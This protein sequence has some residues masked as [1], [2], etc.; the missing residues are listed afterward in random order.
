MTTE[1][2]IDISKQIHPLIE[3]LGLAG[4]DVGELIITPTKVTAKV[5]LRNEEGNKYVIYED[6]PAE[7]LP[8]SDDPDE[9]VTGFSVR[10]VPA[11]KTLEF[12]VRT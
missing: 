3:Q 8:G 4:P 6:A 12:A 9:E 11:T 7:H 1:G 10:G 2:R 5:Y